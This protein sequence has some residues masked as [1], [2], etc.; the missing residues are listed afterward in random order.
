MNEREEIYDQVCGKVAAVIY[1]NDENGYSVLKIST[2]DGENITVVGCLPYCAPGEELLLTGRWTRHASHGEQFKVEHAERHLPADKSGIFEYLASGVIK[3]IGMVTASE[4][5]KRF[6][7][8]TLNI[9]SEEPERL[10]EIKGISEKKAAEIGREFKRRAGLRRLVEFL[11][12]N[13]LTAQLGVK[14]YKCYGESAE[15]ILRLN[16]Y[17]IVG[18]YFGE[19]FASA[20][21]L[22]TNFGMQA[23][24][25][26]RMEAALLF[27][28]RYNL[29]NGHCFIPEEKLIA[30]ASKLTGIA[31]EPLEQALQTLLSSG[32]IVEKEFVGLKACYLERLFCA[33]TRV[34]Q[35]IAQLANYPIDISIDTEM[36]VSQIENQQGI[37]YAVAQRNAVKSAASN[38][39]LV[40]TGGPGTG[41]T[42]TVC[43]IIAAFEAMGLKTVLAAPT[44]RA[45]K[46]MSELCEHEATTVHKL[47]GAGYEPDAEEILF[48]KCS[49]DP[50]DADAVILDE[51]SMADI[52]LLD[53]LLDAMRSEC[54]LVLV[55]D[56]D[57]LPP[58]GPGNP[59]ADIIRSGMVETVRLTDIFRQEEQSGIVRSAHF[60]NN[61]KLPDMSNRSKDFFFMRRISDEQIAET[62]I[63]LVAQRL[64]KNM[65][66]ESSQI[67]VLSPYRQRTAG[68]FNLNRRLQTVLNPP[69][70]N[71]NEKSYGSFVFR[72]GD[73]VMQIRN[74]YDI[75]WKKGEAEAGTGIFNGDMGYIL[76]IDNSDETVTISFDDKIAVYSFDMLSELELAYAMTVHKSQGSE[77]RAVVMAA[78]NG[79]QKLLTRGVLYTAVT[80]A[81]ELMVIVGD[82][83]TIAQMTYNNKKQKR[84]SGLKIRLQNGLT[85][86]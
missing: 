20:D 78:G 62:I 56:A 3:G 54:R 38:M 59:F 21:A 32:E 53:A 85:K 13:G 7:S 52:T 39:L 22:A 44:G 2:V 77:Y 43:A 31:S 23:D 55:G 75:I 8:N 17:I 58:V 76:K 6:G 80:R 81:K 42:T 30:A 83:N 66:I 11:A 5:V 65:G 61:G 46:R 71:K 63:E 10:A 14:L 69:A 16:P 73:K 50:L 68:T 86:G 26:E 4:I 33:E 41:K 24:S 45:A 12:S 70:K 29:N 82:D 48:Q 9:M 40:L 60:I 36:L 27:E 74:N 18:D 19:P 34:A 28:L 15:N 84:Y 79:Y 35:R 67:Q 47:L 72:E 49:S 37:T 57:Q 1:Q 25:P 51:S 64:P